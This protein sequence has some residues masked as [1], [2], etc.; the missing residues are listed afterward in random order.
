MTL[1][2]LS[3]FMLT[4]ALLLPVEIECLEPSEHGGSKW[5]YNGYHPN[6]R[7]F[8]RHKFLKNCTL[9]GQRILSGRFEFYSLFHF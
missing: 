7:L 3:V 8:F 6:H 1:V 5:L 9:K 4:L 2:C